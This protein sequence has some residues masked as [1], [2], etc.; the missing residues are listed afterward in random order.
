MACKRDHGPAAGGQA[1]EQLGGPG[2]G[3]GGGFAARRR[4]ESPLA[5]SA[6]VVSARAVRSPV[7]PSAQRVARVI[8]A[9]APAAD[10]C[11]VETARVLNSDALEEV[12][13]FVDGALSTSTIEMVARVPGVDFG[14]LSI[15]L[16]GLTGEMESQTLG[17]VGFYA[18]ALVGSGRV[19]AALGGAAC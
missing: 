3:G 11:G 10:V 1:G 19:S 9:S 18:G 12:L 7:S 14:E 5:A 17:L 15:A 16:D 4:S 6:I 8:A 13:R 2:R